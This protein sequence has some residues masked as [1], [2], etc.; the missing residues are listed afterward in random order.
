MPRGAGITDAVGLVLYGE[1]GRLH[2]DP[3]VE[4]LRRGPVR[5]E[6]GDRE[7]VLV[8]VPL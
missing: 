1:G 4:A 6:A 2:A 7:E 8:A 3:A 5:Q